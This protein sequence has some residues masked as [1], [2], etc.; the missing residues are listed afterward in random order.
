MPKETSWEKSSRWYNNHMK[1]E[2]G[3]NH[4]E[5]ILPALLPL[6]DL[7]EGDALI[8]FGCGQGILPRH[9]PKNIRYL[10]LDASKSLVQIAQKSDSRPKHEYRHHDVTHPLNTEKL[11]S[12][13]VF[14]LSLQ[15]IA[16]PLPALLNASQSLKPS[17]QLVLVLN[18]PCFRIPKH[19][20]WGFMDHHSGQYRRVDRYQNAFRVALQTHPS[21][22]EKSPKTWSFHRSLSE[23][24][25]LLKEAGFYIEE[26]KE[27]CSNKKSY[28]KAAKAENFARKEIP[29]FMMISA[30][31]R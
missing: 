4:R 2:G 30:R 26:I 7:H 25:Q 21:L 18:H 10:G 14:L 1:K 8:D 29:L 31:K 15:N 16:K 6:L 23:Y 24:S 12:H 9:L 13:G 28:G 5:L 11:F 22:G 3:Y 19:S 17:G 27:I 20:S